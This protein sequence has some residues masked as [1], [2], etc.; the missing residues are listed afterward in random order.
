MTC[1]KNPRPSD[2]KQAL[3]I[4]FVFCDMVTTAR[5]TTVAI[6]PQ[7]WT[8]F[9][10]R[11]KITYNVCVCV[12]VGCVGARAR[13]P[14]CSTTVLLYAAFLLVV[15]GAQK[16]SVLLMITIQKVTNNVQSVPPP[17]SRHLLTLD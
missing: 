4:C 17:V 11:K 6:L 10:S 2:Y 9:H 14:V 15:Q 16:V 12:C 3:R 8:F 7:N 13:G 1:H 5:F